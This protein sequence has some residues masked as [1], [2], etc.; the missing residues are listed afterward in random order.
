MRAVVLTG[1]GAPEK[2]EAR[3]VPAPAAGPNEIAVQM[4]GAS[5]NPIDWKIRNGAMQ[6]N[7]QVPFPHIPGLSY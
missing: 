7:F 5:I 3:E 4:A 1:Y 6:Q 2:L